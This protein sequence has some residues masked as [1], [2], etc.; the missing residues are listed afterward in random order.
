MHV[1]ACR[2]LARKLQPGRLTVLGSVS[3][4][5][6]DS[7]SKL[8]WQSSFKTVPMPAAKR[9]LDSYFQPLKKAQST[10]GSSGS[11]ARAS[12]PGEQQN[13][14]SSSL[15]AENLDANKPALAPALEVKTAASPGPVVSTNTANTAA[16]DTAVTTQGLA[17]A[18]AGAAVP[19]TAL[20]GCH[21]EAAKQVVADHLKAGHQPPLADLILEPTWKAALSV[22]LN[23]PYFKELERYVHGE[24]AARPS[25]VY[26]PREMVFRAFNSCSFNDIKVVVLGQ[27][28]YHGPGQ[29]MGLSFSV[30][31]GLAVPSSL[32]NMYKELRED[33]GCTVPRH[34]DLRKWAAQGVLMLNAVLTVR[35][36]QPTSHKG[37]GWE[38]F[39][40]AAITA[41]SRGRRGVVFMLWGNYAKE[42]SKLIDQTKHH[43][44]T[45][46][47]PSGLSA[48][49]GFF[50]CRH[51]SKAN[52]LLSKA[53]A[54]TIDWQID[55]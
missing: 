10:G 11:S 16:T 33:C 39:T 2:I 36:N 43:V 53:G 8:S 42:K 13:A 38:Q 9:T 48:N 50:G 23:K 20:L 29:A 34:G 44:L 51:F 28:P 4:T 6:V 47:H 45:A 24:W 54:A 15:G 1:S 5:R 21:V 14:N 30:P 25:G 41:L 27:D 18:A 35:A 12:I 31:P 32:Q 37:R 3:V 19:P 17:A 49:R 22:E 26:P 7:Y 40:D 55:G 52:A 46:A